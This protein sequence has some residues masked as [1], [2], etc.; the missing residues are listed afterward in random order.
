MNDMG[1]RK[2]TKSKRVARPQT[3]KLGKNTPD[4]Y[5]EFASGGGNHTTR[6]RLRFGKKKNLR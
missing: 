4:Q 3:G 1:K 2:K 6:G 5:V